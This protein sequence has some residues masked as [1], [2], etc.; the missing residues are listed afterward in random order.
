MRIKEF[1]FG[2]VAKTHDSY[3]RSYEFET[4]KVEKSSIIIHRDLK[5][6]GWLSNLYFKKNNRR[7]E[8]RGF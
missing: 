5:C 7:I 4:H 8:L 1:V 3:V 6:V 2:I